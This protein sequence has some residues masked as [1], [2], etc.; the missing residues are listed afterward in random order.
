MPNS[1]RQVKPPERFNPH[2]EGSAPLMSQRVKKHRELAKDRKR[3]KTERKDVPAEDTPAAAVE[4]KENE[5][6]ITIKSKKK[7]DGSKKTKNPVKIKMKW[8]K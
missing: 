3:K 1:K 5:N 6:Q 4:N 2:Q 7:K 8:K